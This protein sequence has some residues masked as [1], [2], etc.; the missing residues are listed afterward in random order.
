MDSERFGSFRYRKCMAVLKPK[1][2]EVWWFNFDPSRGSEVQKKR[3]AIVVSND[4]SNKYLSRV[5]VVPLTSS[6]EKVYPSECCVEVKKQSCKAM[7]DQ[8]KTVSLESCGERIATLSDTDMQAVELV[9]KL[10]LGLV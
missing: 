2:G 4:S 8:I 1:R 3:P 7:A 9:L 6:I 5:Q 10:Q